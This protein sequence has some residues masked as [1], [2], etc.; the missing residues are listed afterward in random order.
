MF[1]YCGIACHECGSGKAEYLPVG[2]IPGHQR[3]HH[4]KWQIGN[5]ALG[6]IAGDVL[7]GEECLSMFG[8]EIAVKR[9]LLDLGFGLTDGFA[10]LQACRA[11]L[12]GFLSPKIDSKPLKKGAALGKIG[13]TPGFE[14][15]MS[16][17]ECLVNLHGT[18]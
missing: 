2:I 3:Q 8:V 6:G 9:A 5:I 4:A 11:A 17:P 14:S 15:G 10:H 7:V 1:E 12:L 13:L 16:C 18:E